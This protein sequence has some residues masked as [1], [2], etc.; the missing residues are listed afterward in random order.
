MSRIFASNPVRAAA[1][2]GTAAPQRPA[3]STVIT[4]LT[5]WQSA[6]LEKLV[7]DEMIRAR[8]SG[9][10]SDHLNDL[11]ML[12]DTLETADILH[13]VTQAQW[14]FAPQ[15]S[16]GLQRPR[17]RLTSPNPNPKGTE[18]MTRRGRSV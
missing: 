16:L 4:K 13:V 7:G 5:E 12:M 1:H 10:P 3:G 17:S 6:M 9:W 8:E 2:L 11:A 18:P 15:R 14:P